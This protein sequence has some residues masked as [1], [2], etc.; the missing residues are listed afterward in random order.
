MAAPQPLPA[1]DPQGTENL[2]AMRSA[3]NY[4]RFL[5]DIVLGNLHG[6]RL[7]DFGAGEG[8]FAKAL[9]ARV[10]QADFTLVE[11]DVSLC[12]DL[13]AAFCVYRNLAAIPATEQFDTIYSMNVLEHI[14]DDRAQLQRLRARLA[15][16]GRLLL[17]V[18]AFQCLYSAMDAYVGHHR[19][20]HR[21]SLGRLVAECGLRVEQARYV[22][23]LGFMASL[24]Y[25]FLPASGVLNPDHVALYDRYVF[26]VSKVLDKATSWLF[27]K[28][29]LVVARRL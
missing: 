2:V 3:H 9:Q 27:G 18:P 15:P 8:A 13:G 17:Y 5:T 6:R 10:P 28:N 25:R 7:L 22:D 29:L 23:S 12:H 14:E 1:S 24:V 19:R 11:P 26:P 20:Y 16:A 21:R 4:N